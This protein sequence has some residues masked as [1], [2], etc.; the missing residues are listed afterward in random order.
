M[1]PK[2]CK[3]GEGETNFFKNLL[4]KEL[5]LIVFSFLIFITLTSFIG[6]LFQPIYGLADFNFGAAGDWGCNSNTEATVANMD[7]K[8]P[9][10]AFGL[11]DYSYQSTGT[12]WFN[13]IAP[14]DNIMRIAIGNHEDDSDE[15]FS[16]YMSHFGLSQ[17]YYSF[18]HQNVHVLVM[19]T[20]KDSYSSG[21]SQYN[22][23]INDLQ[24]A[25]QNPNIKWIIVYL[26]KQLY[27][28]PNTCGASSCSN[29]AT[30][31]TN[32]R[33][34]YHAKFEQY[35][36][37]L[38]LNGHLHNYQRTYPIKYDPGSPSS[39]TVTDSSSANYIDPEG[40]IF[41]TVG[42][43]GV[44]FHAL[45]GKASFVSSQQDDFFGQLD[46]RITNDGNKLE[47]RF[48]RNNGA[49]LDSFSITKTGNLPPPPQGSYDYAP[50]LQLTGSNYEDVPSSSSLQLSQFSVAA[51]FKTSTNFGSDV[52]IVNK[53][54]IGS[55]SSGQ[56]MNYGIWM[57]SSENIIAGFE[58]S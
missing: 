17:T 51:W 58:T 14:I 15:G 20:D 44:N 19:D 7:N 54:G 10:I 47:G 31:P 38:V 56:N 2:L 16:G 26:H 27:T 4:D 1:V 18:N 11:G 55:E 45:S 41:A 25:S 3:V 53:G 48:Y 24:S 34:T 50:S 12:C 29:T 40:Q 42:T 36:V 13:D 33:N 39:P 30:D 5:F 21:S 46:I 22:F 23:V 35:G 37:D 6:N 52:F 9:E 57:T 32:L 8:N 43:G 49:I 28:S